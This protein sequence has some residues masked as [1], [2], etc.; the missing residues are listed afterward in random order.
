MNIRASKEW[1]EQLARNFMHFTP[2]SLRI[3]FSLI[4][5]SLLFS[6]SKKNY[7]PLKKKN[8][9]FPF[10]NWRW[11]TNAIFFPMV[12]ALG[13]NHD[14]KSHHQKWWTGKPHLPIVQNEFGIHSTPCCKLL[15]HTSCLVTGLTTIR[16]TKPYG[17]SHK[18]QDLVVRADVR[19]SW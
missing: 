10:G 9:L 8:Y 7:L 15:L 12:T 19:F 5:F 2:S 16:A 13:K 17:G 18:P 11:R 14:S 4:Q 6:F 1:A 3:Q